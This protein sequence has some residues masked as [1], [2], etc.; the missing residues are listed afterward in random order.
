MRGATE[1]AEAASSSSPGIAGGTA[2]VPALFRQRSFTAL[3]CGQFVS[4]VGERC[5]YVA[6]I[7]MLAEHTH[8]LREARAAW[9][10][11]LLANIMLAPVLLFAPF[12]GAWI[13]RRN[14][15]SVVVSCDALR[16]AIILLVPVVYRLGGEVTPVFALLFLLFTC[17]VLFLPAKSAL[18][19]E[20]VPRPQLLAANTW[21][22]GAG[23]AAAGLGTLGGAWLVDHWG[24][25][26]V[27]DLNGGTYLLSAL[28]MLAIRHD[29]GE[30]APSAAS[31]GVG[32]FLRELREGWT[33]VRASAT[34]GLALTALGAAWWC[35]GFLHVAG[36]LHVQRAASLP[37]MGRLGVLF[38][39][40]GL[41]AGLGAAWIHSAGRCVSRSL[42]VP[43]A[44]LVAGAGLLVFA[45]STRFVVFAIAALL[46]GLAAAPI[47]LVGET[48]LQEA[49]VPGTRARVFAARDFAM[50]AVLLVSVSA[51]AWFTRAWGAR[52]AIALCGALVVSAGCLALYSA[53]RR[54]PTT[55]LR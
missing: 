21:L 55:P 15:K 34:V 17:G 28:A 7:A 31:R 43:G 16:A 47:L 51:A 39:V 45:A 50:R 10:L 5:T 9:L 3:W 30:R 38:A 14:L 42:L 18:T 48:M 1:R 2:A 35:G 6:L 13:D 12:A 20:I 4:L 36:N 40:L 19:P 53:R 54:P 41:G 11:S 8:G 37:G 44:V 49:T 27:L 26:R 29:G 46:M 25:S 23:I 24:W 22:T 33:I 32:D 52:P